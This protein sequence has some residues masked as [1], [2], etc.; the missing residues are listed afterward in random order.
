VN[1]IIGVAT[2][3][4]GEVIEIIYKLGLDGWNGY[5]HCCDHNS[6]SHCRE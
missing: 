2:E 3:G 5:L 6:V 1:L 4:W